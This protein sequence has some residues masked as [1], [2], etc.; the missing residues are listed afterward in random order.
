MVAAQEERE[1]SARCERRDPCS[2]HISVAL[3]PRT[4]QYTTDS[5]SA[6]NYHRHTVSR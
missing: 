1:V 4:I 5:L 6:I 2:T 3:A